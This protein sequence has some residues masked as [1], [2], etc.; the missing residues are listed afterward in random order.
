LTHNEFG[1]RA[2]AGYDAFGS[3]SVDQNGHGTHVSGTVGGATY[4][5]AK[6][7]RLIAVRVLDASGGGTSS[8]VVAGLDWAVSNHTTNPAVGN[9]SLGGGSSAT[10]D[11]ACKNVINDGIVLCVAAGNSSVDAINTSP[12]HVTE[13]ITVGATTSSDALASYSNFGS[14]VDILAPGSSIKSSWYGS[15]TAVNTISGTSMATPHVTGAA[16]LYLE[17][18]PGSTPAQVASGLKAVA[19]PSKISGVPSTTVNLLL[20][21]LFSTV[22]DPVPAAPVLASPADKVLN[23]SATP[24]LSWNASTYA[25]AYTVQVSTS[26]NFST[27]SYTGTNLTGTSFNLS[28]LTGNTVYYW[29]VNAGNTSGT[30]S[31]S[32]T[33]QFTTQTI[34]A[35]AP[36]APLLVSPTN[37]ATGVS[38]PARLSWAAASGAGTYTVQVS[39]AADFSSL[40]STKSGLTALNVNIG[41]LKR[42]TVYYWRVRAV[43]ASGTLTGSWS[44]AWSFKS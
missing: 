23:I 35:V 41:G 27:V 33:W 15:N 21:S 3:N 16:A 19:T 32:A 18:N 6:K 39:T 28:G 43:D 22:A 1:G 40:V 26:S 7:I 30:S 5:V 9:M 34:V 8:G 10:L 29:R 37:G 44:T 14:V 17:A 11:N 31:W 13:A 4:G 2:V 20:Y 36:A 12:A 25:T 24:T 42:N 38:L